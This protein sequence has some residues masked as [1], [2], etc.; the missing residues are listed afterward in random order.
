MMSPVI[1]EELA[2]C[3]HR[4][5]LADAEA[6]RFRKQPSAQQQPSARGWPLT[7]TFG[8]ALSCL[9][10][11]TALILVLGGPPHLF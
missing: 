5:R 4:E 3:I 7:V 2:D 6:T 9:G 10:A 8:A 1:M 11:V